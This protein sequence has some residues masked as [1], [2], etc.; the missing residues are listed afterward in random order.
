MTVP[1]G[2]RPRWQAGRAEEIA[3]ALTLL[4]RA[5]GY[6][7]EGLRIAC[8]PYGHLDLPTAA[9]P[10]LASALED[11][12]A[13]W[14]RAVFYFEQPRPPAR[15]PRAREPME[16]LEETGVLHRL[17]DGRLAS[18]I[19]ITPFQS[20]CLAADPVTTHPDG[21]RPQWEGR[22]ASVLAVSGDTRWLSESLPE[23]PARRLCDLGTG[24]G[25]LGLL[26]S[27]EGSDA[28]TL[29]LNPRVEAFVDLNQ[30]LN[31]GTWVRHLT[32]DAFAP[33]AGERFDRIVINPPYVPALPWE[34]PA[35]SCTGG[36]L[37]DELL[38]RLLSEGAQ[39]LESGGSL[40]A[41]GMVARPRGSS[42]EKLFAER[43]PLPERSVD[44]LLMGS[45]TPQA[46]AWHAGEATG[47]ARNLE[48]LARWART[49]CETGIE[50]FDSLLVR[51]GPGKG[52]FR[53]VPDLRPRG[54]ATRLR[55]A[56]GAAYRTLR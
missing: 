48:A 37:G 44:V 46:F 5:A 20:M 54:L 23:R 26:A 8:A 27:R 42:L 7:E 52:P 17:Q 38:W 11:D 39:H 9:Y 1:E 50:A 56:A 33:V 41:I 34:T 40:Y 55:R 6:D 2:L 22:E 45:H 29:D 12:L 10:L 51:L 16:S 35:L 53:Q 24:T 19:K 32:G 49:T 28:T 13:G 25:V 30:R 31:P 21:E 4:L 3:H 43:L 14:T 36:P 15:D 18:R 47:A